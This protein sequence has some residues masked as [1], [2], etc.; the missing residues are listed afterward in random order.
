MQ[1]QTS[2]MSATTV[3]SASQWGWGMGNLSS[4]SNGSGRVDDRGLSRAQSSIF[5][6]TSKRFVTPACM[7][8]N[9][10]RFFTATFGSETV[11]PHAVLPQVQ[12]GAN[13]SWC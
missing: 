1:P 2:M 12:G 5:R 7:A 8:S 11:R 6:S 4:S 10:P 3:A 13:G 9:Q